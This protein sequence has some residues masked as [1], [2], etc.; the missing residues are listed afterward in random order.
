MTHKHLKATASSGT[1]RVAT[2][3]T[4]HAIRRETKGGVAAKI[5]SGLAVAVILIGG[6]GAAVAVRTGTLSPELPQA[7]SASIEQMI[8]QTGKQPVEEKPEELLLGTAQSSGESDSAPV[9]IAKPEVIAA[10]AQSGVESNAAPVQTAKSEVITAAAQ[11]SVESNSALVQTAKSEVIAAAAQSTAESNAGLIE[12]VTPLMIASA[13]ESEPVLVQPAEP[14]PIPVNPLAAY[15][16]YVLDSSMD[17]N[18]RFLLRDINGD[19]IEELLLLRPT[20]YVGDYIDRYSGEAYTLREGIVVKLGEIEGS[21]A[22]MG[23]VRIG[24]LTLFGTD[25]LALLHTNGEW[26]SSTATA[27]LIPANDLSGAHALYGYFRYEGDFQGT[28]TA[29]DVTLDDTPIDAPAW[30]QSAAG[31]EAYL[32]TDVLAADASL[33]YKDFLEQTKT[34]VR[35]SSDPVS[36]ET[37]SAY[38]PVFDVYR[39][40]LAADAESRIA[41]TA[42]YQDTAIGEASV[43]WLARYDGQLGYLFTDVNRDGIPELLISST[44]S[45]FYDTVI[46]DLYTLVD[47]R[48]HKVLESGERDRYR[49]QPDGTISNDGSSGATSSSTTLYRFNGVGLDFLGAWILEGSSYFYMDQLRDYPYTQTAADQPL[50]FAEYEAKCIA[51]VVNAVSLDL[52]PLEG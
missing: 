13:P 22:G 47:G 34:E 43:D 41:I 49:L 2:K 23:E 14:E 19:G 44:G 12:T 31:M 8:R 3:A 15:R 39:G 9:R 27:S 51:Y 50:T 30:K 17:S 32:T 4:A 33:S 10:A 1:K 18:T 6:L 29:A 37:L 35:V 21:M 40:F 26:T 7:E 45:A 52:I 20:Y 28:Q 24:R 36:A 38:A 16:Q 5:I 46:Y 11:S 48:P 42:G 25:Y